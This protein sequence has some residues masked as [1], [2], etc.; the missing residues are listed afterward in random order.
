[1]VARGDIYAAYEAWAK[2][3]G[4]SYPLSNRQLYDRLRRLPGVTD[5]DPRRLKGKVTRVFAGIGL[6]S[7]APEA[8]P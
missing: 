7:L 6:V 5:D 8:T 1:V 3:S 4:E 2:R